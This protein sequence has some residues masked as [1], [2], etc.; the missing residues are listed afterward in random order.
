MK[1]IVS[2][3][4]LFTLLLSCFAGCAFMDRFISETQ[5][6]NP[7]ET[8][9][10][11]IDPAAYQKALISTLIAYLKTYNDE[12]SRVMLGFSAMLSF[13][14][15]SGDR[16]LGFRTFLVKLDAEK[17]YYMCGY[18]NCA[19]I[20]EAKN[21]RCADAYTWVKFESA[22]EIQEYYNDEKMVVA[23][24]INETKDCQHLMP[25]NDDVPVVAFYQMYTAEFADGYNVA[26]PYMCDEPRLVGDREGSNPLYFSDK[27]NWPYVVLGGTFYLTE[28]IYTDYP[29]GTRYTYSLEQSFGKY[30]D[31]LM[32]VMITGKYSEIDEDGNTIHYGLFKLEDVVDIL[33]NWEDA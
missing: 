16:Q 32:Q 13:F 18:Y 28:R 19:H 2:I 11:P 22:D 25:V 21:Y 12:E 15:M 7:T 6:E 31:A 29:N 17:Y 10:E 1:R 23:F 30:R 33:L 20:D 9:T 5:T 14:K 3:S 26:A 24:Q 8:P 4:L 27:G